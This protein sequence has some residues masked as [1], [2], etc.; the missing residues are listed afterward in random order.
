[1]RQ[2]VIIGV[3]AL[4]LVSCSGDPNE[5]A[6]KLFV[7]AQQLIERA[8]KQ[9]P[10]EQ[11]QTLLSAEEKLKTIVIKYPAA[12]L[13]VQLSSGQN[14]GNISLKGMLEV[15]A[16]AAWSACLAS[17]KRACVL[18]QAVKL[19]ASFKDPG[20]MHTKALGAIAM[21][22]AKAGLL[23]EAAATFDY[24]MQA[25]RR[26]REIER[27]QIV[28]SI[29]TAQANAGFLR[30]ARSAFDEALKMAQSQPLTTETRAEEF[31]S[32]AEAQGKTG[33]MKEASTTLDRALNNLKGIPNESWN[34]RERTSALASIARA[35]VKIG[36]GKEAVANFEQA[37]QVAQSIK[38]E[39]S[40]GS[41]LGAIATAYAR[42]G[43]IPDAQKL[44]EAIKVQDNYLDDY[45]RSVALAAL[46]EA[47]AK[48]G[49]VAAALQIVQSIKPKELR[50]MALTS[51]A[52]SHAKSG[53]IGQ[54][55][56]AAESIEP[57]E[58]R[59][60]AMAFVGEGQVRNGGATE[61]LKSAQYI[62]KE[63]DRAFA[64]ALIAVAL[65]N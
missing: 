26:I 33:M 34:A 47:Q 29:G 13:A 18:N 7:E 63:E 46:A 38:D 14:I 60:E 64:L 19:V 36:L 11:L 20:E 6:N 24:A 52:A 62:K 28:I 10:E 16:V 54:A 23:K 58:W 8:E 40:R 51:I 61:A 3:F 4:V 30:E 59:G 21:A 50:A 39:K 5:Q 45:G 1:M 44:L 37:Q 2:A 9:G 49:N 55:R 17:P 32:L 48:V 41:A 12:N 31:A 22:Q 27:I 35:Q 42:S 57:A 43:N 56:Q 25:A 53:K 15:I 65:P